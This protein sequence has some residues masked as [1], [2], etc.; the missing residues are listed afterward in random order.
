MPAT[1]NPDPDAAAASC[2]DRLAGL[3][4]QAPLRFAPGSARLLPDS[5]STLDALARVIKACPP[6]VI[7]IDLNNRAGDA[8][9]H[10]QR[11]QQARGHA[12]R[13]ALIKRGLPAGRLQVRRLPADP[14]PT[15][16]TPAGTPGP[17]I[18]WRVT[19][20]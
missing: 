19:P 12:V 9:P 15:D 18:E 4:E 13:A 3:L 14:P 5:S 16:G 7:H 2:Q 17:R 10:Q 6:G 1:A 8:T 20:P 11:L